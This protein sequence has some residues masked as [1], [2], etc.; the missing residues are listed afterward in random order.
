[1]VSKRIFDLPEADNTE[2]RKYRAQ[3]LCAEINRL[4]A[5]GHV[6]DPVRHTE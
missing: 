4:L 1:M 2:Q 6:I 3:Q 5:T